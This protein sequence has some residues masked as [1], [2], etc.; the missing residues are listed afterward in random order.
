[1]TTFL[2]LP[3]AT[4]G[5]AVERPA[6]PPATGFRRRALAI[7]ILTGAVVS[8][9][10]FATTVWESG[11]RKIDYLNSLVVDPTRSQLAAIL[12][13]FGYMMF[14][15]VLVVL[16]AMTRGRRSRPAT[17]GIGLGY[18][19]AVSLPGLLVT[20]FYDLAIRQTLPDD[21]AVQVS[22]K[23]GSYPLLAVMMIP[24]VAALLV[25]LVT[26]L[27]AATRARWIPWFV[28]PVFALGF[29]APVVGGDEG[30]AINVVP[31]AWALAALAYVGVRA[32]RM[33]DR[34]FA[35]GLHD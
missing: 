29:L 13:H 33:S 14:V 31:T 21:T 30:W 7:A 2:E 25:G 27:L 15:P 10:G 22:D 18:L 32:L 6:V 4:A 19:G 17:V 11:S 5:P 3:T 28:A 8:V 9:A 34:E 20:D 23:A 1:M 12:L 26:A 16:A 35:T 24:T